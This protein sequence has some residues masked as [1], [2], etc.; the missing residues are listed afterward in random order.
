[1][2]TVRHVMNP[3][4]LVV[5]PRL[6]LERVLMAFVER[7][8]DG[9]VV[10]EDDEVIGVLGVQELLSKLDVPAWAALLD[11]RFEAAAH[12]AGD[13]MTPAPRFL[14]PTASLAVARTA[15]LGSGQAIVPV[16]DGSA[17][18]GALTRRGLIVALA[19]GPRAPEN[20]LYK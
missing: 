12:T 6:T 8:A 9:A 20:E 19:Q 14:E 1:M 5:G 11:R 16:L 2:Y 10:V 15:L 4:P 7:S 18:V 17:L 3:T 13:L